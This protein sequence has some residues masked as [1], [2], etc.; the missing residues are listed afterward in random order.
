MFVLYIMILFVTFLTL[1][2]YYAFVKPNYFRYVCNG[3]RYIFETLISKRK[4]NL[5]LLSSF[6]NGKKR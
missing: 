1:C 5:K 3:R 6:A 2:V 4:K